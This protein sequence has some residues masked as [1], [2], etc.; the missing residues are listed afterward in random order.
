MC[1]LHDS[2]AGMHMKIAGCSTVF[3][4][5]YRARPPSAL[6]GVEEF[7]ATRGAASM[8]D[9][10]SGLPAL[11]HEDSPVGHRITLNR[12]EARACVAKGSSQNRN[13]SEL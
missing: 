13:L 11:F 8:R 6:R 9:N 10:T 2:K 5:G 3:A 7:L 4:H 12:S 1:V